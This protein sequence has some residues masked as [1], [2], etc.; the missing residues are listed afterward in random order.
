MRGRLAVGLILAGLAA[1]A[2]GVYWLWLAFHQAPTQD[3]V[4]RM[5][6]DADTLEIFRYQADAPSRWVRFPANQGADL[7]GLVRFKEAYWR[8]S[9]PPTD[10]VVVQMIRDKVRYG[11][12]EV[13]DDGCLHVRKAAR[14]YKMPI[15]PGFEERV[16][17]MLAAKGE[18]LKPGEVQTRPVDKAT[19]AKDR[20]RY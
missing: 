15:E 5:L 17:E 11:V 10:S 9:E 3:A 20:F 4:R 12:I 8:F 1:A 6:A 14:W 13:R 18:D 19:P 7:S 16:R 2:G